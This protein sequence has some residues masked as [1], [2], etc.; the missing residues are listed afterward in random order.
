M[1]E[2][3]LRTADELAEEKSVGEIREEL[4]VN[5]NGQALNTP[6]NYKL[7]FLSDPLLKGAFAQNLLTDRTDIV[8]PL[9]WRREEEQVT[10]VD[11]QY[12]MIYLDRN[13][14]LSSEKRIEGAIKVAANEYSYHPIRDYLNALQWDGQE[15]VRHA[16][17]HFLGAEESKENYEMLKVFMLGAAARVFRPGTKFEMML[18]LVG[19]QGAGKSTFFR[20]L[21]VKDDWFSDD[22]R[23]L[24]DENVYRRLQG[25]W[26]IEMSEM[27]ATVN[28]KSIEDIKSFLSRQKDTYKVPYATHPKDYKRQCVFAGTSNTLD[29]LPLDRTGNRRFL[30]VA[31][32]PAR[33]EVHILEDEKASR[34]YIDQMW[35]EV[36][37]EYRK[38]NVDL[39]L[40]RETED[41]IRE[42][43]KEFM[44][45]DTLAVRILN[46]LDGYVGEKVCSLQLYYEALGHS[47]WEEP[48]QYEIRDINSVMNNYAAGWT[49]FD[50]PRHFPPP[51]GRQKGWERQR[52]HDN[53]DGFLPLPEAE[54]GQMSLPEEWLGQ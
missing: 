20:F 3:L 11:I 16:L 53:G 39:G 43:Q 2:A 38:G 33:A 45:E 41:Y 4:A 42:R 21:S 5:S 28:A 51:Y 37:A 54:A 26:I 25:H 36:M 29:F 10:D 52:A 17:H 8:K 34:A 23:R 49:R 13:Y 30:P 48:K 22:L 15:R 18:C 1:R 12:L 19:G 46:F 50:S 14:R 47:S 24:E 27:I 7:I 6:G 31:V 32:D 44:P 35:A 40:S 9:G